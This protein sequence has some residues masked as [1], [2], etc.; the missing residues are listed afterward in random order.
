MSKPHTVQ[1]SPEMVARVMKRR[2]GKM[3]AIERLDPAKT[4]LLV[5]DM[6]NV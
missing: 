1:L 6:Q 5:I 3:H 4:A 2:G